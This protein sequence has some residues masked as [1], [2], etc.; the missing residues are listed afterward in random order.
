[1]NPLYRIGAEVV[2]VLLL[3]G[4]AGG[5]WFEHNHKE[6]A[7][8]EQKVEQKDAIASQA[9]QAA[10]DHESEANLISA[11]IAAKGASS[12]QKA[13]D[14]YLS[15]HPVGAVGVPERPAADDCHRS[16]RPGR[17]ADPRAAGGSS[18]SAA[19]PEVLG[20]QQDRALAEILSSAARLAVVDAERQQR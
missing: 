1:V 4:V 20:G 12:A 18:G 10:A 13:V 3:L 5:W 15:A 9:V 19:V 11:A 6:Q 14:D 17:P 16:V 8:G 7:V 2:G